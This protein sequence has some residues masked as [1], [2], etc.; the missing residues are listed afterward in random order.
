MLSKI[1]TQMD[2]ISTDIGQKDVKQI[3]IMW[4]IALYVSDS[5]VSS[6]MFCT[7]TTSQKFKYILQYKSVTLDL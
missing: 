4:R 3:V 7:L 5:L 2:D 6:D 1:D